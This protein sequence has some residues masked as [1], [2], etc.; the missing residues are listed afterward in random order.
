MYRFP[1][2]DIYRFHFKKS[3]GVSPGRAVE[4]PKPTYYYY[5]RDRPGEQEPIQVSSLLSLA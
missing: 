5:R 1:V 2:E 4:P 3:R